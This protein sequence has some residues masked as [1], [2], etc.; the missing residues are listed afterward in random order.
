LGDAGAAG[1]AGTAGAASIDHQ[2]NKAKQKRH[3][4]RYVEKRKPQVQT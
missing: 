3:C 1:A 2:N 4:L